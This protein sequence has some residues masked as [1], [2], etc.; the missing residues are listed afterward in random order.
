M[1]LRELRQAEDALA[2]REAEAHVPEAVKVE[3]QNSF[4]ELGSKLPE[5]W[6]RTEFK[7]EDK[8]ALLRSLIDKVVLDRVER[9]R[10][11]IRIVWRGGEVSQLEVEPR[12]HAMS[13]LSRAT[14]M[15][16][17]LLELARQGVDD[18][19]IARIL[20]E[21][22]HRSARCSYVPARTVQIVRQQHRVLYNAKD[23]R[24]RHISGWLTIATV[25]QM[26]QVSDS[27]IKRR[28]R[29]GIIQ[30]RRDPHD[31]RFLFPNTPEAWLHYRNSSPASESNSS[32]P[33]GQTNE[34]INMTDRRPRRCR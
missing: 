3:D 18:V 19:T 11:S 5:I 25:A 10:I 34:G 8:K 14:E 7:R 20:T 28:I 27:W 2:R 29:D 13:A 21:E 1:A 15:E 31:K 30:I 4:L 32:S 22:G 16:A 6:Q 23:M 24:N 33:H 9:D 26:L 17:R 12:V